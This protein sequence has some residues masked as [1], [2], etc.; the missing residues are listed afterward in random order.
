MADRLRLDVLLTAADKVSEPFKRM[1]KLARALAG[2][3]GAAQTALQKLENQQRA[4]KSFQQA[5]AQMRATYEQVQAVRRS[6]AELAAQTHTDA[7]AQK[8]HT[9]QLAAADAV[10]KRLSASF[11]K[12]ASAMRRAKAVL[13]ERG[14][15][16]PAT[17]EAQLAGAIERTTAAL[18]R[19]K[20]A[21]QR[22]DFPAIW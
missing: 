4:L 22:V 13:H 11:E 7:Q 14:I 18:D 15:S 17:A 10:L 16:N 5:S 9:A 2:E 20:A 21:I 8:A 3:V 12:Q 6:R 19:K 1:G